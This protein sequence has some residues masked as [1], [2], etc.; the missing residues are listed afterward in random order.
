MATTT[1]VA[2][3]LIASLAAPWP[4]LAQLLPVPPSE[5]AGRV[6]GTTVTLTWYEARRADRYVI[7]VGS[8]HGLS[9]LATLDT[10]SAATTFSAS[11]VPGG[12][13]H[14]RVRARNAVGTSGP[15]NEV[16]LAIGATCQLPT[17]SNLGASVANGLVT[18]TWTS[19]GATSHRLEVGPAPGSFSYYDLPLGPETT[20][21]APAPRGTYYLRVRG[22]NACGL[23]LPSSDAIL[24]VGVPDAPERFSASVIGG[25]VRLRWDPPAAG[26]PPNYFVSA[27]SAPWYDDYGA[28]SST[29]TTY[30]A[31]GVPA[32]TYWVKVRGVNTGGLSPHSNT[33]PVR[34]GPPAPGVGVMT[35]A[36]LPPGPTFVSHTEG[37]LRLDA[38]SGP[39]RSSGVALL[40]NNPSNLTALD[41][42]LKLTSDSGATFRFESASLYSSVTPIPY[43]FRGVKN[44]VTVYTA[45][46]TVPNTFGAF[47]TVPNPYAMTDVDAVF[48]TVTNPAIPT[49]PTCAGNPVGIDDIVVRPR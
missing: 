40:S 7:E 22:Q 34:V 16:T 15:S 41:S 21:T 26:A 35:F 25:L 43:V 20:F 37:G 2:C 33:L 3:F 31:T 45:T 17:A 27:G 47:A 5:L 1:R 13:Y 42:E 38:V 24:A 48:I 4:A 32:G 14:V 8:S 10:G 12:V 6:N 23:G 18:L 39:W 9:D 29:A 11:N 30:D 36:T 28:F 19:T 49:C 46:A 44:G